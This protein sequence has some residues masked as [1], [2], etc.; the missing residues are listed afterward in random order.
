MWGLSA[1]MAV[2]AESITENQA[3]QIA[4]QFLGGYSPAAQS[5]TMKLARRQPLPL[6]KA[7]D[8][9]AYYVFNVGTDEGF[10]IVSGSDLTPSIMSYT[11]KG[12][13]LKDSIPPNV[14]AWLDGY[15]EQVAFIE[16]TGGKFEVPRLLEQREAV[17][18]LLKSRWGQGVPYN[19]FCPL[20]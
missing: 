3:E 6:S 18:P 2:M 5:R 4:R 10:V 20:S 16:Q 17:G 9:A 11:N 8:E 7:T 13:Y 1:C 19:N 12:S 14:Q 15:A